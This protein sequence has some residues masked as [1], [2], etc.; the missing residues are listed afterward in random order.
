[1]RATLMKTSKFRKTTASAWKEIFGRAA[2]SGLLL[3][4][5]T[6]H[7]IALAQLDPVQD[8]NQTVREATNDEFGFAF[9]ERTRWE[10]KDGVNFGKSVNQQDMLSRLRI[11]CGFQPG[12]V[13]HDQC[14]GAGRP[15]SLVWAQCAEYRAGH[16]GPAGGLHRAF[17]RAQDRLR[18]G[19]RP[20]D[21][22]FRGMRV[23][24]SPQWGN[25]S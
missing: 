16:H 9:E 21:A 10:E 19:F 12:F 18:G 1:M 5:L 24:G 4:A 7:S 25:G 17:P 15:C 3:A 14:D 23:N 22:Q 6:G 8:L 13:V 11:G 20:P 2:S